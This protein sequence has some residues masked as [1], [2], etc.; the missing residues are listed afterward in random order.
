[1]REGLRD[2]LWISGLGN[3]SVLQLCV[4]RFIAKLCKILSCVLKRQ[5]L[6]FL[7]KT[8]TMRYWLQQTKLW[9]ATIIKLFSG[10]FMFFRREDILCN[11]GQH[12][13]RLVA[14]ALWLQLP[15]TFYPNVTNPAAAPSTRRPDAGCTLPPLCCGGFFC[16]WNIK[17][18][19]TLSEAA[20]RWFKIFWFGH[21]IKTHGHEAKGNQIPDLFK[22]KDW[23][24]GFMT[25][26]RLRTYIIYIYVFHSHKGLM[27]SSS[28]SS[29]VSGLFRGEFHSLCYCKCEFM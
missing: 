22:D 9:L 12:V 28:V 15:P 16:R 7:C 18:R 14:A 10:V 4:F 2:L 24:K 3:Q 11:G 23:K 26:C 20:A 25:N 19:F 1:M 5:D 13:Y 29:P 8:R 21:V 27:G 6:Q 17:I